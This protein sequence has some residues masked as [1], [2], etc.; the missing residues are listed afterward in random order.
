VLNSLTVDVEEWFHIC[1]V[2]ALR[3]DMWPQLPSRV[4]SNTR[5]VLDELNH[6]GITGT[7]FVVGWVATRYP[8]LV[9]AIRAAGHQVGSHS[10]WHRRVYELDPEL[11]ATDLQDSVDALRAAGVAEVT[12]FR[13]PEWSINRRSE[14][15]LDVLA[16][17]GFRIDASMA[18]LRIVGDVSFP[19]EPSVRSTPSGPILEM[20]PLVADRFGHVMPMGWGWG[21]RMSAPA[22]VL[23]EIER[24]NRQGRPAVLTIHPW[25][26]DP[27]PP[28]ITLPARLR[29][30]HYFRLDGFR[31]RLRTILHSARFGPL[32]AAAER[33]G[34]R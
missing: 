19:R 21:L 5:L 34:S 15:A 30:A 2:D 10:F 6:A 22:R 29:F 24:A 4:E 27:E 1:G 18:P 17:Q 3:P 16:R 7:F 11:F 28:R 14:W 25:E 8:A 23:R 26:L 12:A 32:H 33:A 13:A 20:P 31:E 9:D